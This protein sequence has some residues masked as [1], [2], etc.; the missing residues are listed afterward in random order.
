MA[1]PPLLSFSFTVPGIKKVLIPRIK[2]KRR[3]RRSYVCFF[4]IFPLGFRNHSFLKK[5]YLCSFGLARAIEIW[6]A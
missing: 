6:D 4:H 5:Y 2:H 1:P 3:G